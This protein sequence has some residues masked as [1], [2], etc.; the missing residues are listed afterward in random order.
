[1]KNIYNVGDIWM[2][3][4]NSADHPDDPDYNYFLITDADWG[5]G[6]IY[7]KDGRR[8]AY[9]KETFE[10]NDKHLVLIA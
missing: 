7:L 1:M 10:H 9:A 5:Y 6:V 4:K 8:V 2:W 3:T